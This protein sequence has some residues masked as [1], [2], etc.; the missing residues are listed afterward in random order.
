MLLDD[1]SLLKC[2]ECGSPLS[3][4]TIAALDGEI[5]INGM[6]KCCACGTHYPVIEEV[7]I[8]FRK[9]FLTDYLTE[10][11][12]KVIVDMGW[13][14]LLTLSSDRSIGEEKQLAVS[15]NWEYQWLE[16]LP[17]NSE[18]L[19]QDNLIGSKVFWTFIPVN[20][21]Y[22]NDKVVFIACGGSGREAYHIC[23]HNPSKVIINEIGS[24]I[25]AAKKLLA[26]ERQHLLFLR[27]DVTYHPLKARVADLTICDH[28]L[29]HV[30]DYKT[31]FFRLVDATKS[32]G[33]IA[34]CV[35]SYEN[36]FIMTHIVEPLKR[37][38]HLLPL[39]VQRVMAFF[40]ALLI[41][42]AIHL[43]YLPCSKLFSQLATYLPLF[44]HMMFWAKN[45]FYLVWTSCF[46]L[47]HAPISYHF[48][49]IEVEDL[50]NRN[51]LQVEKIVHTY[52]TTWSF[53]GSKP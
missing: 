14:K 20:Q 12:K 3:I 2:L 17:W 36:N 5:I 23:K 32:G 39:K 16:V 1:I 11:E 18:D 48:H 52:G 43:F 24:E 50:A 45:D 51:N 29:Q 33:K 15:N 41:Y 47:I 42:S 27:G 40:P 30:L 35:Y 25:Y 37:Y 10:H 7:G 26:N 46:D 13:G 53:V 44:E 21:Q 9:K 31:A 19:E 28:A 34:I 6:L 22:V 38:L 4:E 49:K 8:F